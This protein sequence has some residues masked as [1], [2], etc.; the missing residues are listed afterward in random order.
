MGRGDWRWGVDM[1]PKSVTSTS[2]ANSER[3]DGSE[4]RATAC[5]GNAKA[6]TGSRVGKREP[7]GIPLLLLIIIKKEEGS[8][9]M[10]YILYDLLQ[11]NIEER[12]RRER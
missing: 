10:D 12:R 6:T 7:H 11:T 3:G 5:K 4:H 2:S 8:S 1:V 9:G